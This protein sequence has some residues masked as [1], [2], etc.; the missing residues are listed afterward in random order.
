M[1]NASKL[2][3]RKVSRPQNGKLLNQKPSFAF[4][5]L[6]T[7]AVNDFS[8][9]HA[10]SKLRQLSEN[11]K[12]HSM[13]GRTASETK[14]GPL[15]LKRTYH[16][17]HVIITLCSLYI[18]LP[19]K[20]RVLASDQKS[21]KDLQLPGKIRLWPQVA[22]LRCLGT[23]SDPMKGGGSNQDSY[24]LLHH[25]ISSLKKHSSTQSRC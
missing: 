19:Q 10:H 8:N 16:A 13:L 18:F 5:W 11:S 22:W 15:T 7:G 23:Q 3:N 20:T 2:F 24:P 9:Q 4:L 14:I 25:L 1:T 21:L 17:L 6:P 12:I